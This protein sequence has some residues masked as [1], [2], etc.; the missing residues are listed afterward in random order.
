MMPMIATTLKF[1]WKRMRESKAPTPAEGSVERMVMGWMKL[2]YSTPRTI[3][4]VTRAARI[5]RASLEREFSKAA[6]VPWKLAWTLGGRSKSFSTLLMASMASPSAAFCARLNEMVTE[7]NWP[8]WLIERDSVPL[9]MCVKAPKGT[10]LLG[11]ELV[12]VL[13]ELDPV[14]LL[15]LVARAFPGGVSTPEDGVYRTEDV[16]ALEP[17]EADDEAEKDVL[18]AAPLAPDDALA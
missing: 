1:W 18:A 4:T 5:S 3:Y 2:S 17:A 7:G 10:A 6:A 12:A 16:V 13:R 8:W 14:L 11:L 9:V 15:V